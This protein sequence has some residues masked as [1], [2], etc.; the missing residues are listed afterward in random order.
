M[1]EKNFSP[2]IQTKSGVISNLR[3]EEMKIKISAQ[4]YKSNLVWSQIWEMKSVMKIKNFSPNIHQ[5]KSGVISNLRDEEWDE[6][7]DEETK[8][9]KFQFDHMSSQIWCDL[10]L[11][12]WRNKKKFLVQTY[13]K[14]NLVLS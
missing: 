10:K 7:L 4:T 13:I 8:E 5:A 12:R 14:P 3:D 2:N 11:E 6:E 1:K 9:K